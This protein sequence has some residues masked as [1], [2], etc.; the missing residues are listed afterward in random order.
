MQ[1]MNKSEYCVPD[2]L[3]KWTAP[4]KPQWYSEHDMDLYNMHTDTRRLA[5]FR[6]SKIKKKKYR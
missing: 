1:V 5:H 2:R 3:H 4:A 6:L